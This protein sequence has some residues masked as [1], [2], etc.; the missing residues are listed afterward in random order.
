M[1][2]CETWP[3]VIMRFIRVACRCKDGEDARRATLALDVSSTPKHLPFASPEPRK[4]SGKTSCTL[5]RP[6]VTSFGALRTPKQESVQR[7][8]QYPGRCVVLMIMGGRLSKECTPSFQASHTHRRR[9]TRVGQYLYAE[10]FRHVYIVPP[11]EVH[12]AARKRVLRSNNI[13]GAR[14]D[15]VWMTVDKSIQL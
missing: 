13:Y 7:Q 6:S 2:A 3:S 1:T 5:T 9:D 12:Q 8:E 14:V 10:H 4:A 15:R 11:S